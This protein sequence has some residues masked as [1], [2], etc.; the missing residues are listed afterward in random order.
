MGASAGTSSY[1]M[2]EISNLAAEH[3]GGVVCDR[4]GQDEL[5]V[6]GGVER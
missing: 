6:E 3:G 5:W 2:Q 4:R 1:I